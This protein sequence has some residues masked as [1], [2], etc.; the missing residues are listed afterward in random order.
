MEYLE[1]AST[2]DRLSAEGKFDEAE[3]LLRTHCEI[4]P[5][6]ERPG[7]FSG[8][9][10]LKSDV[11]AELSEA[12]IA[13]PLANQLSRSIRNARYRAK[14]LFGHT[15]LKVIDEGDSWHQYP[16]FLN[17]I[18]D[19]VGQ[20]HAVYSLSAAG[21][22][23]EMID[24]AGEYVEGIKAE[25]PDVF[26][27]SAGGNDL[28]G[29]GRLRSV[30]K[31]HK[32]GA[33]AAALIDGPALK[34]I[35]D[36][37]AGHCRSIV[38]RALGVK[39]SL[40]IIFHG[41]DYP[42]PLEG[43]RW[44]GGPLAE[45]NIPLDV[46]REVVMILVD[47]FNAEL[48]KIAAANPG[49]VTHV[50]LRGKVGI[51]PSVWH[52]ELHPKN[53]G[54]KNAANQ[55][56]AAM[57]KPDAGADESTRARG[58]IEAVGVTTRDKFAGPGSSRAQRR[59]QSGAA[60]T[61]CL[62]QDGEV[63]QA[64]ADIE[65]LWAQ[66]DAPESAERLAVRDEYSLY[67]ARTNYE[68]I[69]N[70]N[71][72]DEYFVLSR[73]T[74]AGKAVARLFVRIPGA[75]GSY[76]TGFLVGP[77]L[78]LTNNHVIP[79]VARAANAIATFD[80]EFDNRGDLRAA[81]S[82]R[83]KSDLFLTSK[84][85]D[86]SFVGIEPVS[87]GG[88]SLKGF[89]AIPMLPK[90]GKALKKE[91]VSIIQHPG[92][93]LKKVAL[94]ENRVIGAK[95]DFLY[96]VTDT[97]P[98][99][100]GSPVFNEEW[101]I[102]ALH[103]MAVP[104][105]DNPEKFS[106]NRGVRV[107]SIIRDVTERRDSGDPAALKIDRLLQD[108]RMQ[109]DTDGMAPEARPAVPHTLP[110]AA[111][112]VENEDDFAEDVD[113]EG[114]IAAPPA[115]AF[116]LAPVL[117]AGAAH[118][119]SDPENAPDTWHL[120]AAD[121]NAPF[122]LN[123]ALIQKLIEAGEYRPDTSTNGRFVISLRGCKLV[124]GGGSAVD[125]AS[126]MLQ[127]VNPDHESFRCLIGV[128]DPSNGEIS[129]YLG[130]TVPRRTGMLK[131]YNKVNFG[132]GVNC[133]MLPT[134]CYEH[135]VGTHGGTAGP[136]TFVL[137]LG[138]GPTP[139]SAGRAAVLRTSNDLAYGTM[140]K[141][142]DT[143][144][145]DNI[146]PAFLSSSFSSLGCLTVRGNQGANAAFSS[147]TGEWRMFRKKLGFDGSNHAKRFDNLL[148]TGHEAASIAAALSSGAG[149]SGLVCLRQGSRGARVARLQ[150]HLGISVDGEFGAGTRKALADMQFARLGF[151]TGTWTAK[152]AA[153]LGLA[154]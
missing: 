150:G 35:L 16:V 82:F 87:T 61:R 92:G 139:A 52:D 111:A 48:A 29:D 44:L 26:I 31:Q 113:Q 23:A 142:D 132:S 63:L 22:T 12:A 57:P 18:V 5:P 101:Q 88:L 93:D 59:A 25:N 127:P 40:R 1:L 73:G 123:A 96:Y 75:G 77:N 20:A 99:S 70:E 97:L 134:G 27:M 81:H 72:L 45:K 90:S 86:Y 14:L 19:V 15:G 79:D 62:M 108:G 152:M 9:V 135:C 89:G 47:R 109:A 54:F 95:G 121:A 117:T 119:P 148:V 41:Y 83:L 38:A 137:R 103:H 30:L 64:W 126:V 51:G 66:I 100:S 56:M 34:S 71:N 74:M 94:R 122:E 37:V 13:T 110:Q 146:H 17:D 55:V 3:A 128:F 153:L 2:I 116:E 21:D 104:D 120:P 125:Q 154:F 151:A 65:E 67:S 131:Y 39:P 112:A 53:P 68:R 143:D 141:W 76:G 36:V 144:P 118:W 8:A 50:D 145:A 43:G 107:S 11:T 10:R 106:A 6:E 149:I 58:L 7:P 46:G 115:A 69:I 33:K 140:D 130:S 124:S 147:G 84:G 28:L 102:A 91:F 42:H 98:G 78:L 129:L 133:N 32:A 4:T 136:V 114:D 24:L 85:L 60:H 49:S 80:Y 138:N 105:K